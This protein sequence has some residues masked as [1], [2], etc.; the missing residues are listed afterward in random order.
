MTPGL[1]RS[2]VNCYLARLG[3]PEPS[4]PTVAVLEELLRAHARHVP[5]ENLLI[6][7]DRAGK[8]QLQATVDR[9]VRGGGG[10]CFELNGA[11]GALL[12]AL[13]FEVRQHEGRCWT[14]EPDPQD[15]SVN[16]LALTVRCAD[17]SWWFAEVGMSDAVCEPIPLESGRYSQGPFD[18][19]LEAITG[20]AG[21]GWRFHH[22][23]DG[24]FG[25]MDFSLVPARLEIIQAAHR[26]LSTAPE[27]P[28]T[29]LLSV[30]RRDPSGADILRGRVLIRWDSDG[31][32][33][34]YYDDAEKWFALLATDLG[35]PVSGLRTTDRHALW[36]RVCAAH[37]TWEAAHPYNDSIASDQTHANP[38]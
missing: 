18:Y 35:L 24:S 19:E 31:R 20:P 23:P 6:Q 7:L 8:L 29:R 37:I 9:I 32:T 13:G 5:F 38:L 26:R 4:A 22:D 17:R 28:F 34:R 1:T 11:F 3:V 12:A 10:Y 2:D 36:R 16:H 33:H 27:S 14:G 25:G 21:P 15:A 30:G